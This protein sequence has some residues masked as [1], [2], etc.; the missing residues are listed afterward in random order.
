MG[1]SKNDSSA[2]GTQDVT[3]FLNVYDLSE[4]NDYLYWCGFGV[5]HTGVEV[6]GSEFAYGGRTVVS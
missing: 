5:F 4:Q 1:R 3:V 2:S 6:F